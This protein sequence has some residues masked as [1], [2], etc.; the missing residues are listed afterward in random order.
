MLAI[1]GT[2]LLAGLV[3]SPHCIG[4][5]GGLAAAAPGPLW[6]VGRLA[7]YM[8]LGATVASAGW[9]LPGPPW[10]PN[11]VAAVVLIGMAAQLAGLKI[12][13]VNALHKLTRYL[14][15]SPL[16]LGVATG[17]LPCGL[18]YAALGMALSTARP[19]LGAATMLAFWVGTVPALAL[20][21]TFVRKVM[22]RMP[23]GRWVVAGTVLAIG[24]LT[25]VWRVPEQAPTLEDPPACH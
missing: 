18:I 19:E 22:D 24:L 7:T 17:L 5:C 12:P 13:G 14:P 1:L 6:H 10:L 4:M 21:G 16:W 23:G 11:A 9:A 2:A 25:V 20:A 8:T 3:G 15:K